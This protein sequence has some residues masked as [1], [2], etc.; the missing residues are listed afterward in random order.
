MTI[1]A[2]AIPPPLVQRAAATGGA[3]SSRKTLEKKCVKATYLVHTYLVCSIPC[4]IA[5]E[6]AYPI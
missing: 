3:A 5:L 6:I 2:A 4:T 1:N